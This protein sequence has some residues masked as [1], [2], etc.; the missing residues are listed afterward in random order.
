MIITCHIYTSQQ[1]SYLTHISGRWNLFFPVDTSLSIKKLGKRYCFYYIKYT[2]DLLFLRDFLLKKNGICD[3]T[4]DTIV[5][6]MTGYT[7]FILPGMMFSFHR[8]GTT[9]C[10][11]LS[12]N[13]S[14]YVKKGLSNT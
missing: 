5:Q 10:R 4:V 12:N 6:Y 3:I 8:L 2:D 9:D 14:K 13:R 1:K 11:Q 7:E